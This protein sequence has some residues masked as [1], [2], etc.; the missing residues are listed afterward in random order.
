M[1]S[2]LFAY[3]M[4]KLRE[5][6]VY[7]SPFRLLIILVATIFSFETAIMFLLHSLAIP[8]WIEAIADSFL[9]SIVLFPVL[10]FFVFRPLNLYIIEL[11][12]TEDAVVKAKPKFHTLFD[13]IPDA[14]FI[15]DMEGRFIDVNHSACER[16][17]YSHEELLQMGP[18]DI[19][20]PEYAAKVPERV[21][22]LLEQGRLVFESAH[23]RRDG[24][25]IPIELSDRV[26]EYDGRPAIVGV[27]R[28]ISDRKKAEECLE[29]QR[30]ELEIIIDSSPV[31]IFYKDKGGRFLRVNKTFAEALQIPKERFLGKTVF[32]LY[33]ANIAQGMTNDDQE[34]LESGCP[35]I[36]IVEQYESASG[37]RW[38]Q[39]DKVPI[40][41]ADG[42]TVGLIGFAQD[43]TERKKAEDKLKKAYH[44]LEAAQKASLNIME[45]LER[46]RRKLDASLKE[47]EALLRELHHRVKNNMQIMSSLMRLQART[48]TDSHYSGMFKDA[49]NRITAMSLIHEKLYRSEDL[50]GIGFRDYIR[51]L[52]ED[53]FQTYGIAEGRISLKTDVEAPDIDI[54][55]AIPL[56]LIINE[57]ITNSIK[58]AFPG[59][60]TG[61]IRITIRPVSENELELLVTDNGIGIPGA[62]DVRNTK[63]L[64]MQLVTTLTEDQL[65]GSIEINRDKGT[66]FRIKFKI[67]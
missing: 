52:A 54:D 31:I 49:L 17:G 59:D 6:A 50:A 63:T 46:E 3:I 20:A 30:Q 4:N 39:T 40:F 9:L 34:V 25:V 28:D 14:I 37:I 47:R 11:K 53:L 41:S 43:I 57:L 13:S 24:V 2:A 19:A 27:A 26:I 5:R 56:G 15:I 42:I 44:E 22:A 7:Q 55:K 10:Y 12:K 48:I 51:R 16:L 66:E 61:E 65:K 1:R 38:V 35:K 8:S 18:T 58:Y 23:V 60:R 64:G 33:S 32:D 29:K 45:D 62:L 67:R 36:N 21:K